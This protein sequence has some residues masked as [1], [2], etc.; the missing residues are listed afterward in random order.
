MCGDIGIFKIVLNSVQICI[1]TYHRPYITR[2]GVGPL[3]ILRIEVYKLEMPEL[4]REDIQA[5]TSSVSNLAERIYKPFFCVKGKKGL[6][7]VFIK[8]F[9]EC[10]VQKYC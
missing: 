3:V 2:N 8:T 5:Y 1:C 7:T 9:I 10:F 4:L 6:H